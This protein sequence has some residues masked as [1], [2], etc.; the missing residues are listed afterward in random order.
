MPFVLKEINEQE[1]SEILRQAAL[2]TQTLVEA[3]F[4][5]AASSYWISPRTWAVDADRKS[6]LITAPLS[7]DTET[8]REYYYL[9]SRGAWHRIYLNSS[10]S[11]EV[12]F[13]DPNSIDDQLRA[14][15]KEEIKE[16]FDAFGRTGRLDVHRASPREKVVARF[17]GEH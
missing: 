17:A 3:E 12:N 5:V 16:A 1:R 14:I 6:F 8:I 10:I 13:A 15:L 9:F 7:I 2:D 11:H 4:F